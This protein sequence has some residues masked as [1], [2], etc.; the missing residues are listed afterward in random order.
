MSLISAQPYNELLEE[1]QKKDAELKRRKFAITI[2]DELPSGII[3]M[4]KYM[5]LR[6]VRSVSVIRWQVV[7]V[8]KVSC[9]GRTSG[10]YAI[11]GRRYV[12]STSFL[13]LWVCHL[14]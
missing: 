7:T 2:G 8:I 10:G 14:V 13:T 4:A 6:N 12:L 9:H 1:I 3:Q 5:W 11:L